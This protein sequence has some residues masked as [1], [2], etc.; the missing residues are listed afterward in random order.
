MVINETDI[1]VRYQETDQMGVVYHANYLVWFEIGRTHLIEQLGFNYADMER[2]GIVSPVVD[3]NAQYKKP[4]TYGETASVK[5]YISSYDGF[6][7][8]YGYEIYTE[9][10]ELAVTGSSSHVCV[11]KQNFKPISIRKHYPAWHNAYLKAIG[12]TNGVRD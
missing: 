9:A 12:E 4:L 10:G 5:T 2:D 1:K 8:I 6:R 3:I 11:K 7:I